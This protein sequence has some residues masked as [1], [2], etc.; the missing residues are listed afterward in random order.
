RLR[1]HLGD[2]V[3]FVENPRYRETNSLYS[4]WLASE[5]LR[6]GSMVMNADVLVSPELIAKLVAAPVED[7]LL[8]EETR[9]PDARTM[10]V[11]TWQGFAMDFG[12]ELPPW[13][14]D[15]ENVGVLKFGAHGGT[16]LAAH[17]DA[18]IAAGRENT[19]APMA[20]RALA[21]EWPLRTIATDGL[22]WTEIDF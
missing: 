21:Q 5:Q 9:P 3:R 6:A 17:A 1:E 15:G 18:L 4:L 10:K 14:A 7:A 16:R 19:W 20:F 12:K 22:P 13:D 2:R 8:L 11:K